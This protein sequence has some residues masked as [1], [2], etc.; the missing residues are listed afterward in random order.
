MAGRGRR[1][2]EAQGRQLPSGRHG[3]SRAFVVAHQRER[4][5]GAVLD[6]VATR[7][8]QAASVERIASC[9]GVSRRTFYEQFDGRDDAFG[10]TCDAA[11]G[12][13]FAQVERAS[14]RAA[15][16]GGDASAQ[17]RA[18]LAALLD[19]LA[20]APRAAHVCVVAVLS[21][22]P[23]AIERRDAQMRRFAALLERIGRGECGEPLPPLAAEG[24]VGAVY[25]VVYKRIAAGETAALPGL[26]DD[27]HRF[28]ALLL[29]QATD[30]RGGPA[31][32]PVPAGEGGAGR[33]AAP[34]GEG[35]P[36]GAAAPVGEGGAAM[37]ATRGA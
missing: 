3:L 35:V 33:A 29:P 2:T 19:G 31:A 25:D 15:G 5:M 22:G 30:P 10:V 13:L 12:V 1:R 6:V 16:T 17:L 4:I 21:A 11:A 32:G 20:G 14:A 28:C 8:W 7:G 24:L 9:A 27:L 37:A 36:G 34:V 18:A 23:A 26:L